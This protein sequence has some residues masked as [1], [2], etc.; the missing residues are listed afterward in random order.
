MLAGTIGLAHW[1]PHW[2]CFEGHPACKANAIAALTALLSQ[3]EPSLDFVN[4]IELEDSSYTPPFGWL[5]IG[6]EQSCG[7]DWDTLFYRASR[8]KLLRSEHGCLVPGR[9]YA[10]GAFALRQAPSEK[11]TILGAHF[12]QTLNASTHAYA[13]A[14]AAAAEI[15]G[16]VGGTERAALLA[17]TN[18]EGPEAAAALPS[19][20][21]VNRTNA[22][23]LADI[24]LWP[25]ASTVEPPAAPLYK[26]CCYNDGFGWQGD[27]I[28]ANFGRVEG[29]RVL[30]D[31]APAWAA[32]NTS[33]FHKGIQVVL[34]P[35]SV[36]G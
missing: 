12:P 29:Y 7:H 28:I 1:N 25:R 4:V 27:R 13:N 8:W 10:I 33:E 30:F 6:A 18:T 9:S 3:Q 2:Q 11:V 23:L 21:G 36:R 32:F 26:G 22:Q 17:D 15:L 5:A 35:S 31:P 16:R 19:H 14:T 34:A 20:H 24:G